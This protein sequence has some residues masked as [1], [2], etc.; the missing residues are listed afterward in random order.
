MPPELSS[1]A[2]KFAFVCPLSAGM[3]ARPA[4]QFAEVANAFRSELVL[5]NLRNSREANTKSVLSIIAADIR[6]GDRCSIHVRGG[7]EEAA[8]AA[9]RR[10][11]EETLPVCDPP[12]SNTSSSNRGG[13]PRV[14]QAACVTCCIGSAASPGIAYGKV[15]RVSAMSLPKAISQETVVDSKQEIARLE[16]AM[17]AVRARI[18][19]QLS[20]S[21]SPLG[22]T[23]LQ[24]DLSIANDVVFADRIA[25]QVSRGK[26]AGYAVVETGGYFADL[27]RH[28]ESEYIRER[29]I[30]VEE[31]SIQILEELYGADLQQ[32]IP[33]LR[34]PSIIVAE[35]LGPQ[36]LLACDQRWLKGI[37]LEHAGKTSHALILARAHGI[38]AVVGVQDVRSQFSAGQEIVVD[39]NRGLVI[40]RFSTAVQRFYTRE[41]Q[42]LDRQKGL[43]KEEF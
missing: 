41:K 26:S 43:G 10:F 20:N 23:V 36:Q 1:T 16:L 11:V 6:C 31:I 17:A 34:E 19:Q 13:I 7:D 28:S 18:R 25:E 39:A 27:L 15:V 2:L 3:H 35:T 42:T 32:T 38:P 33:E 37:V 8:Y 40:S 24:A 30:D 9:V 21:S 14:L 22:N 12:T 5:T 29:A 4:S